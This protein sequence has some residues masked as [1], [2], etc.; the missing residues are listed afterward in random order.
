MQLKNVLKKAANKGQKKCVDLLLKAGAYVNISDVQQMTPLMHS[1]MNG[2]YACLELLVASG[3]DV[4]T[5]LED[6]RTN[7]FLAVKNCREKYAKSQQPEKQNANEDYNDHHKC[8]DLLLKEGANVNTQCD[9]GR[10]ALMLAT[11]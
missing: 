8:I 5:T 1:V 4:N 6:G 9:G 3:A 10:T 2:H 7:M 11:A